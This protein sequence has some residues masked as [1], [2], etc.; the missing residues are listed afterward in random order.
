MT[1]E[2]DSSHVNIE[3]TVRHLMVHNV[4]GRFGKVKASTIDLDEE[5]PTRSSIEVEIDV[6]SIDTREPKRDAHL[7]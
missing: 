6:A 4:R 1:W 7:L 2:I 5:N 3:F